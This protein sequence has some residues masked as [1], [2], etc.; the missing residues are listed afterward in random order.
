MVIK[1]TAD[2]IQIGN[3][4]HKYAHP[5]ALNGIVPRRTDQAW[6][7]IDGIEHDG[8]TSALV[9]AGFAQANCSKTLAKTVKSAFPVKSSSMPKHICLPLRSW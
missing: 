2:T 6:A 1:I 3:V 4:K 7:K 9:A 8:S 5:L